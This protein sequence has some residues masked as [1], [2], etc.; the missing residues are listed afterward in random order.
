MPFWQTLGLLG[1]FLAIASSSV[2]DPRPAALDRLRESVKRISD[3]NSINLSK[4][5]Q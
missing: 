1:L 2:V 4:H 3:Q 5:Q